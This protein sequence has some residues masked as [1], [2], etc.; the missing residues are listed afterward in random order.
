MMKCSEEIDIED[1]D[2]EFQKSKVNFTGTA[3]GFNI[4]VTY[5]DEKEAYEA[6]CTYVHN[7]G[8]SVRKDHHSYEGLG[9]GTD[10]R[11]GFIFRNHISKFAYQI[12]TRAQGNE[13]AEQYMLVVMK[14]MAENIDLLVEE[15]P[16]MNA[17]NTSDKGI[18]TP[19]AEVHCPSMPECFT[20]DFINHR[21]TREE[22]G[23]YTRM[24]M[25]YFTSELEF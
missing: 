1:R 8:F 4:S 5:K 21:E 16:S 25:D 3:E 2:N 18:E 22:G 14:D 17:K 12:S 24:M 15:R 6:Y 13:L 7:N 20:E 11:S 19:S 9:K 10:S 23:P